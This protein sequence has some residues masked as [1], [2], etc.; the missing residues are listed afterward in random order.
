LKEGPWTA[1]LFVEPK[2][3]DR[4]NLLKAVAELQNYEPELHETRL[5]DE[6]IADAYSRLM[7]SRAEGGGL[8]LVAEDGDEF[9][10]FAAGW[11]EQEELLRAPWNAP[12]WIMYR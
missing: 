12:C 9:V 10:G 5:P 11:I 6:Q 4:P 7:L 2:S 3:S 1:L 8:V